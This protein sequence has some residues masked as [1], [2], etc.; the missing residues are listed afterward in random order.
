MIAAIAKPLGHLLFLL[1]GFVGNY[2]LAII[3]FTII[4][5]GALY[6]LTAHQLKSTKRMQEIQPKIQAIQKK[7]ANDKE[8]MNTK[9]M[10]LYKEENYNPA[11]G[12]LPLIIQIPIIWGLFSLLRNPDLYVSDQNLLQ[13]VHD[14]F[15]WI[16]D[17]SQP[18]PWGLP[19]LAGI[20]TF[21]SFNM[22]KTATANTGSGAQNSMMKMMQYFFP[23]MIVWWGHSFPAGLTLYWF[24]STLFQLVQQFFTNREKAVKEE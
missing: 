1:N 2:G 4:L 9:I 23:V 12:C 7:Y 15:I 11:G 19:I 17:L 13:A 3:I 14:S 24:I 18:D 6:P 5:K 21:F 22:N 16:S 20:T 8:K 10:E